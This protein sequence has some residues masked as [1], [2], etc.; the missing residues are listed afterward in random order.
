MKLS[1][2]IHCIRLCLLE[3]TLRRFA[4]QSIG[5]EARPRAGNLKRLNKVRERFMCHGCQ[6]PMGES[7]SLRNYDR[8]IS[9]SDVPSFRVQWSDEGETISWDDGRLDMINFVNS[10]AALSVRCHINGQAYVWHHADHPT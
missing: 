3:A 8:A 10:D 1:G 6:A 2:L 4:H 5:W 9:Q 7:I